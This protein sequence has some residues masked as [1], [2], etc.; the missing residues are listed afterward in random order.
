MNNNVEKWINKWAI[1]SSDDIYRSINSQITFFARELFHDYQPTDAQAISFHSR[2]ENWLL[3]VANDNDRKTLLKILPHI[4]YIGTKEFNTLYRVAY[5]ELIATWLIDIDDISFTNFRLAQNKLNESIRKCWICPITDSLDINSFFHINN[6][7]NNGWNE[8]RPQ[9]YGIEQEGDNGPLWQ[10]H[11]MYINNNSIKRLIIIEDFVGSGSQIGDA[12]EFIMRKGLDLDVLLLPLI[13]C[14]VGV[15]R[16]KNLAETYDRLSYKGVIE[17]S[18][19]CFIKK[20]PNDDEHVDF[21]AIR[22]LLIRVYSLTS[23]GLPEGN[24]KPYSPFGYKKTGGLVIMHSNTPDNTIPV[25]HWKSD[26]WTPLF[27]R[28]SRN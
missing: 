10:S 3:N 5:N 19:S 13:I 6:I 4:F 15:L 20:N 2:L 27:P 7:P 28:H 16:F 22:E 17:L 21:E 1:D 14:P 24:L 8:R 23:G 18:D 11:L 9:W 25:V 12:V 26:N